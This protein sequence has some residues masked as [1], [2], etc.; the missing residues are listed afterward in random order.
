MKKE[1]ITLKNTKQEI[2][3]ALNAALAREKEKD[4]QK[5]DPIA[6]EKENKITKAVAETK[7]NVGA[8]IFSIELNN[9]FN[10]LELAISAE[11]EKLKNLY[12]IESELL[13][14]TVVMNAGK[15]ALNEMNRKK[16]EESAKIDNLLKEKEQEFKIKTEN[17]EKEYDLKARN[18]KLEREREVEEYNYKIK[19][20]RE[21]ENN[22]WEDEKRLRENNLKLLEAETKK[23]SEEIKEK[24]KNIA[25][26]EKK[27]EQIPNLLLQEYEKGKK[28]STS[29]LEKEHKY[30]TELLKKDFQ[31]TI[32]R[33]EDKINA[34]NKEIEK[35]TILNNSLQEKMDK[36]YT[37]I[38]ELATRTV[39]ANGGVKILGNNQSEKNN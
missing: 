17:L 13:N 6:L 24:E 29:I 1:E 38:K 20:E 10:D 37:E 3:D 39:E 7:K 2:L 11:E 27:V 30:A 26:L 14:L 22:K 12:S 8:D 32:D 19:R 25:E 21:I 33:Q 34:L 16:E 28:E 9:K 36:A 31:N 35:L 5:S 15:D 4:K 23:S 18:L